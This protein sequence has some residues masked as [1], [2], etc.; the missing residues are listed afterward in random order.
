[1]QKMKFMTKS[2]EIEKEVRD[3]LPYKRVMKFLEFEDFGDKSE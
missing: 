1:M 3:E 2:N